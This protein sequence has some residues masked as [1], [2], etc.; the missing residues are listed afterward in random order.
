[1]AVG[2]RSAIFGQAL[3]RLWADYALAIGWLSAIHQL[4]GYLLVTGWLSD[5][6]CLA[7][8]NTCNQLAIRRLWAGN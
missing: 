3:G 4:V 2:Y 1:M 7:I 5:G 6:N 8:H